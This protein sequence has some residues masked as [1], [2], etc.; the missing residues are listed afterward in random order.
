M[1]ILRFIPL[2]C[3]AIYPDID[4]SPKIHHTGKNLHATMHVYVNVRSRLQLHT[5]RFILLT[6]SVPLSSLGTLITKQV[7]IHCHERIFLRE[8][9]STEKL[10]YKI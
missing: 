6:S 9:N 5:K 3:Y 7:V 4:A 10:D 8:D 1:E 2:T